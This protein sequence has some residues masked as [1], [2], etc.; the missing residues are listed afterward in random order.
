MRPL[1]CAGLILTIATPALAVNQPA[2]EARARLEKGVKTVNQQLKK[3]KIGF[4]NSLFG[5]PPS[6]VRGMVK[7]KQE[8]QATQRQLLTEVATSLGDQHPV[9]HS[10]RAAL[11]RTDAPTVQAIRSLNESAKQAVFALKAMEQTPTRQDLRTALRILEESAAA[12]E[13]A[14]GRQALGFHSSIIKGAL[15]ALGDHP[16]AKTLNAGLWGNT[17]S[18]DAATLQARAAAAVKVLKAELAE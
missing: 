9:A 13:G 8:A 7:A 16:V 15:E 17:A 10:L 3:T 2:R 11:E 6:V 14:L 5:T 18:Q 1:L 4:F 12:K